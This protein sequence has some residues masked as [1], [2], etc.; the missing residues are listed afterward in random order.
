MSEGVYRR[1]FL[2]YAG[3]TAIAAAAA[4]GGV[5]YYR[6]EKTRLS[7]G[8]TATSAS[9]SQSTP[10]YY[11]PTIAGLNYEATRVLNDKVYD[12]RLS[13]EVNNPSKSLSR[14][15]VQL[16]P[17]QYP[18]LPRQAFPI[19]EFR[20][21]RPPFQNLERESLTVDFVD[22][23]GGREYLAKVIATDTAGNSSGT[24]ARTAYIREFEN[25]AGLDDITV[26]AF[27]YDWYSASYHIPTDLPDKPLLGFYTSDDAI[28]FNRHVDWATG[29]GIDVF[30]FPWFF[31]GHEQHLLF[32]KNRRAELFDQIKFSFIS[33][34][35]DRFEPPYDFDDEDIAGFFRRNIGY[36]ISA[37]L[38]LPNAWQI[39][40]RPVIVLWASEQYKGTHDAVRT[41][42]RRL[43]DLSAKTLGKEL[44][45]ICDDMD[46]FGPFD[47]LQSSEAL[48]HYSP[49]H[50]SYMTG[51]MSMVDDVP[52]IVRWMKDLTRIANSHGKPYVPTLAPGFDNT[53]DYRGTGPRPPRISRS[54]E[55]FRLYVEEVKRIPNRLKTVFLTSF[56]EWFE[57][58]QIEPTAGYGFAYL[59]ILRE[60][61]TMS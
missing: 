51:D 26:A 6:G 53:H 1:R 33:S 12:I 32:E 49:F 54:T 61:V 13:F 11:P 9:T 23:K 20:S 55:G 28:V 25:I 47:V 48:Y 57:D 30:V 7:E 15:E 31:E 42:F 37:Y 4:I 29:H 5:T 60:C 45:V 16:I 3:A 38:S 50:N 34:Y 10:R 18:Q 8:V 24:E 27:Y 40:G 17:V 36:L 56:N 22:L 39:D 2:K 14:L 46:I 58:T 59:D 35:L 44:C 52:C 41:A 19:E 21:I 43:R